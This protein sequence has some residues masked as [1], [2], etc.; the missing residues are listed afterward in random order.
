MYTNVQIELNIIYS[1]FLSKCPTP[2]TQVLTD[3]LRFLGIF[4]IN[5]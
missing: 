2:I 4:K 1:T 5:S 3:K